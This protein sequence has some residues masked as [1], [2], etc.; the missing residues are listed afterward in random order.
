MNG[1]SIELYKALYSWIKQLDDVETEALLIMAN[2][3]RAGETDAAAAKKA[4]AFMLSQG[5][6]K[7]AQSIL[8]TA[9]EWKEAAQNG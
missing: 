5:R 7:Q 8:D 9:C 1:V 2:S 3:M 6:T 4:A